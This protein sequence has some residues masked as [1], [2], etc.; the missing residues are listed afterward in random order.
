M[1]V[2]YSEIFPGVFPHSHIPA[3]HKPKLLEHSTHTA[4]E[5]VL[6]LQRGREERHEWSPLEFQ[7]LKPMADIPV[8]RQSGRSSLYY[9]SIG[10]IRISAHYTTQLQCVK[11]YIFFLEMCKQKIVKTNGLKQCKF[12]Q[13]QVDQ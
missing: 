4:F 10:T 12:R 7:L 2:E 6:S 11:E 13:A 9:H 8:R 5:L 3:L 1:L